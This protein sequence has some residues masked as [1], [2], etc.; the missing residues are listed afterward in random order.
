MKAHKRDICTAPFS[1]GMRWRRMA[2]LM[3]RP[4]CPTRMQVPTEQEAGWTPEPVWMVLKRNKERKEKG[5][6]LL[7]YQDSN[8]GPPTS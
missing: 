8:H 2:N 4:L 7:P 6:K 1:L 3:L 5:K